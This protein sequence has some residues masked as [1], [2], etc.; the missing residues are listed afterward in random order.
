[1]LNLV[2]FAI[3]SHLSCDRTSQINLLVASVIFR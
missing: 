3:I 2:L 1:M